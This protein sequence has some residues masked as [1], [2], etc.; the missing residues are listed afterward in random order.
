MKIGD[1][2]ICD[3]IRG[4]VTSISY[5]STL[6]EAIDGSVIAFTNSQL[7]TKNYKNMTKNHGYELDILEVGVAYG[8]DIA[9]VKQLL[10]DAINKL[11]CINK[12]RSAKIV[13]KEFGDSA[14]TLKILVWVNV[15]TQY[16]DDGAQRK[17]YRDSIPAARHPHHPQRHSRGCLPERSGGAVNTGSLIRPGRG[18][19]PSRTEALSVVV[20][21]ALRP[22]RCSYPSRTLLLFY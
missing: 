14:I 19:Y 22:G 13:L 3:G 6:V 4:K 10:T 15:L 18:R 12:R 5:T 7:F 17:Q 9:K 1:Y 11:P 2:I 8:S 20:G 16:T 21:G